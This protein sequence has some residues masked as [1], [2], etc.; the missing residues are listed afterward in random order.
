M[1]QNLSDVYANVVDFGAT[2]A[3]T[4]EL[5]AARNRVSIQKAIDSGKHVLFPKGKY[6]F[7]GTL[8]FCISNQ[9]CT[10]LAGAILVPTNSEAYVRI[11]YPSDVPTISTPAV[12]GAG[13][14][15]TDD[16]GNPT[17]TLRADPQFT[18]FG[19]TFIGFRIEAPAHI[20]ARSPLVEIYGA[21]CLLMHD[22]RVAVTTMAELPNP[23]PTSST[24]RSP[25]AAVRAMCLTRCKL[26]G[27]SISGG[28]ESETIGLWLANSYDFNKGSGDINPN[29]GWWWPGVEAKALSG[30]LSAFDPAQVVSGAG[31]VGVIGLTIERF[32][33]AVLLG[34]V[35]DNQSFINCRF[36]DNVDGSLLVR[37]DAEI[38]EGETYWHD[39]KN[40]TNGLVERQEVP[41]P[42]QVAAVRVLT[43][44]GCH[45]GGASPGQY[46][47]VDPVTL[48]A[49]GKPVRDESGATVAG[50][51]ILGGVVIGC[52]FGP[53][54][55]VLGVKFPDPIGAATRSLA[56]TA[57]GGNVAGAGRA[58]GSPAAAPAGGAF[59]P[60]PATGGPWSRSSPGARGPGARSAPGS[61]SGDGAASGGI[62][63][64]RNEVATPDGRHRSRTSLR[65]RPGAGASRG[66]ATLMEPVSDDSA[67]DG[68]SRCMFRIL[69][70][71]NGVVVSG[72]G[73]LPNPGR[74]VVWSTGDFSQFQGTCDLFNSWGDMAIAAGGH[75]AQLVCLGKARSG[76]LTVT[77]KALNLDA[78]KLGF[79]GVVA[80]ERSA[81]YRVLRGGDRWL[82]H[83]NAAQVLAQLL[84]D[85]GALGLVQVP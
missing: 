55:V 40:E 38:L 65:P 85:L 37:D 53:D 56:T 70:T 46:I 43:L 63:G 66:P 50:G 12:D 47:Q 84:R 83:G 17:Y 11:G 59:T 35:C 79:S 48:G 72:C 77:A 52:S 5:G 75:S 45:M 81:P 69:G 32:G 30:D 10:F 7:S 54:R 34:C 33:W 15:V 49:D 8:E 60:A 82:H 3:A 18:G 9:Q 19:Q 68:N 36:V 41:V 13:V 23:H 21:D 27:G 62:A 24:A 57:R 51:C 44:V 1:V 22:L 20:A 61:V 39:V 6:L 28:Q 64:A 29:P 42:V 26:I 14:P 31:E 67:V 80:A 58:R 74:P 71:M 4:T 78:A 2:G 25:R 73:A 16:D 76:E